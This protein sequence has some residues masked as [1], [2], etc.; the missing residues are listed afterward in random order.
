[1]EYQGQMDLAND[2]DSCNGSDQSQSS[3]RAQVNRSAETKSRWMKGWCAFTGNTTLKV[4]QSGMLAVMIQVIQSGDS[5]KEV[6]TTGA[7]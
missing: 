7:K 5:S 6:T 1:M 3:R 2:R 4:A